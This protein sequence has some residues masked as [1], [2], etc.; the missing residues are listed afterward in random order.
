MPCPACEAPAG[1]PFKATTVPDSSGIELC[2]RCHACRHEW[3]AF[4]DRVKPD[5]PRRPQFVLH[6]RAS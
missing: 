1:F 2:V 5:V 6:Q 4:M 3:P